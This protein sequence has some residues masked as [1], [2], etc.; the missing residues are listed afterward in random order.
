MRVYHRYSVDGIEH[1][2]APGPL[3]VV[4]YHGRPIAHDLCMLQTLVLERT[5]TLP[6]A[7]M[8][9]AAPDAPV[10]GALT[11]GMEF[12]T[13]DPAEL[14]AAVAAGAKIIV[15]PGGTREGCRSF[16]HRQEVDW[17]T[18]TGYLRLA[19][20]HQLPIVPAA[21][22]GVDATYIGLNDGYALGKRLNVPGRLP[23]WFG[24]GPLGLWPL[25]PPF[26]VKIT[27]RLGPPIAPPA[28]D[29]GDR[30]ALLAF[31]RVVMAAVQGLMTPG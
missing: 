18:R 12:L 13:G 20:S 11:R 15:T 1:I 30:P 21:G 9:G 25:S 3:L 28:I 7:I 16:H 29:P 23:V 14:D 22:I 17:G 8:H 24:V 4:G 2:E 5:G 26:P 31:H 27:T 10:L 19:I 6:R